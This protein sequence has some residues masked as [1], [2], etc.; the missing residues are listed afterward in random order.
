MKHS[1]LRNAL[2]TRAAMAAASVA[3]LFAAGGAH[4]LC[5]VDGGQ[6]APTP[7]TA[8][9]TW[10]TGLVAADA[11]TCTGVVMYGR[12]FVTEGAMLSINPGTVVRGEPRTAAAD[13]GLDPP[14]VF[15][16]GAPGALIVTRAGYINADGDPGAPVIFTTAVTDNDDDGA[17][18]DFN[19]DGFFD[20]YPGFTEASLDADGAGQ[21]CTCGGQPGSDLPAPAGVDACLGLDGL[22]GSA[23]DTLG[24]CELAGGDSQLPGFGTGCPAAIPAANC[25][26]A[27]DPIL[28]DDTPATNPLAPINPVTG[29][30][31]IRL[32]GGV[33]LLGQ[34]GTNLGVGAPGPQQGLVE[35][36]TLPGDPVEFATYGGTQAL[37]SSGK[38][39]YTSIRHGG[40]E[41]GDGNEINALTLAGVGLG[42]EL[43]H[44]EAY[45]NQDDGIEWFGGTA[46]V[47]YAA[48]H[49]VG[50]DQFDFDQGY[51][52]FNQFWF[53]VLPFFN[54]LDG[55]T[56]GPG[57]GDKVGE[58]DGD[59]SDITLCGKLS[60]S[61]SAPVLGPAPCTMHS[62]VAYNLT[63]ISNDLDSINQNFPPA[64]GPG[65]A[66]VTAEFIPNVDLCGGGSPPACCGGGTCTAADNEGV[67][68]RNG[69]AGQL[70]NSIVINTGAAQPFDV[71]DS[72]AASGYL[73]G[74]NVCNHDGASGGAQG[75]NPVGY[76]EL[77]R[78]I[79]STLAD[80]ARLPGFPNA[81][82]DSQACVGNETDAVVNGDQYGL[83]V[84]NESSLNRNCIDGVVVPAIGTG[85]DARVD[86]SAIAGAFPGLINEDITFD[87]T[88]VG[89][90]LLGAKVTPLNPRP[91][92]G[93][94]TCVTQVADVEH[95]IPEPD[96]GFRGAFPR[97]TDD[98]WTTGWTA[99]NTGGVLAD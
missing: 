52:G 35:G 92:N 54:E 8:D 61:T 26:A 3:S 67:E 12:V 91:A 75:Q 37:D 53:A 65:A 13:D 55:T 2:V 72:G 44:I 45:L 88:G 17:P 81:G 16:E 82:P 62:L 98:L 71:V 63:A 93:A 40:D 89:G 24:N 77:V 48:V 76:G 30:G 29:I 86:G 49:M 22:P 87:P 5:A 97:G 46:S 43:H 32:W 99:L 69:F 11:T 58:W 31:N 50:D 79:S 38:I 73:T 85:G 33:V 21:G 42:T 59:D 94:A 51:I 18:D 36:L 68:M 9:V 34:A 64:N 56:F 95:P 23:D 60:E 20:P 96:F 6:G 1:I 70:R 28:Y 83:E 25:D 41:L 19:D 39:E 80:G 74:E 15:S 14:T 84:L 78:V 10:P 47:N 27:V 90:K 57:S 4:A 7:I 66:F